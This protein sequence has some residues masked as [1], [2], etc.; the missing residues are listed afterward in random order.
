MIA[1]PSD[2]K[3]TLQEPNKQEPADNQ[4]DQSDFNPKGHLEASYLQRLR[5]AVP[6]MRHG[7]HR[8]GITHWWLGASAL[9]EIDPVPLH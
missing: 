3:A 4:P 2:V 5:E 7:L 9:G 1:H 8:R 6:L